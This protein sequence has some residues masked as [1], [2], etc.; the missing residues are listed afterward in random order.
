MGLEYPDWT[1]DDIAFVNDM[2]LEAIGTIASARDAVQTLE[3]DTELRQALRRNIDRLK[4]TLGN[5]ARKDNGDDRARLAR[6]RLRWPD[7]S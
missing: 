3:T 7:R 2:T 5:T 6:C 4:T 1:S